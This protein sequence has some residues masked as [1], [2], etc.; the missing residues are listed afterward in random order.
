MKESMLDSQLATLVPPT[1]EERGCATI[2]LGK[3]VE[4]GE[5]VGLEGVVERSME[6]VRSWGLE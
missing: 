6:V 2:R 1:S 5:E 3:G 4:E